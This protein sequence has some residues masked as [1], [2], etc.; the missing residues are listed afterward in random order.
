MHILSLPLLPW[1]KTKELARFSQLSM[2]AEFLVVA[3]SFSH[4]V[5]FELLGEQELPDFKLEQHAEA[6]RHPAIQLQ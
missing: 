1:L 2:V 4:F 5:F 3:A 6:F